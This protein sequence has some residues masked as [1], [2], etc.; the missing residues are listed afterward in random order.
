[1]LYRIEATPETV[2]WGYFDAGLRPVQI[3]KSGDIIAM[4]TITHHAG[5][6]PSLMMDDRV[7]QIFQGVPVEDRNPG[8]HIMTGPV[9]VE[10]AKAGD[11]LQVEFLWMDVRNAYG[12]NYSAPW[13]YLYEET[14]RKERVTIYRADAANMF[15]RAIYAYDYPDQ[16]SYPG[17]IV[18]ESACRHD[19][20]CRGI[21]VPLAPHLGT[22]GVA[23]D[24]AGR[25]STI[26]PGAHGGN[27]D[28][29]R[30]GAGARMFYPVF[31]DGALFSVGDPHISQGDGELNGTAIEASLNVGV[32]VH[33]RKD[34]YFPTPLLETAQEWIV[35]GFDEDLNGAM[36]TT[37]LDTLRF[38]TDIKRLSQGDAYSLASVA[39]NFGVTQVVDGRKG[40]HAIIPKALFREDLLNLG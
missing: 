31:V 19:V 5:D 39:C 24:V 27:I 8:V 22:A 37:A 7:E 2:H 15:A 13:G 35:H 10:G 25:V 30:I 16:Y 12:S 33:V 28:N 17:K 26:P 38:L 11:M 20:A 14:N 21:S 6:A 3:V 34:F 29:W 9:Y 4:E 23:P 18:T 40:M 1:M 32:R 36:R